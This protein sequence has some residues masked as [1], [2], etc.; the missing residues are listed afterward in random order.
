MKMKKL[1]SA[2]TAVAVTVGSMTVFAAFSDVSEYS[3]S[4]RAINELEQL[5]IADGDENGNFNPGRLLTRAEFAKLVVSALGE[6]NVAQALTETS[7]EDCAGH[8]AAG[9]IETGVTDGFISGYSYTEFGPDDTVTY[10]QAVKM[11]VSA[12]GYTEY[13]ENLGGWPGGY[14]TYGDKLGI[15][16]YI[17]GAKN[18]T[19]ITRELA[20][21]LVDNTIKIPLNVVVYHNPNK[22]SQVLDGKEGR[23]YG[24]LLTDRHNAYIVKGRV[25]ETRSLNKGLSGDEVTYQIEVSDN[26]D[27]RAYS[28]TTEPVRMKVGSTAAKDYLFYYTEAIVRKDKMTDEYTILTID[29]K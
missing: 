21:V 15:T 24:T 5:K 14:I 7:F 1:I 13:A 8:W 23:D 4:Y 10:A 18:D 16:K 27:G 6:D 17:S 19:E 9:Y 28:K 29:V 25:I 12:I 2:M 11:L 26:F 3:A 20:A 22:S